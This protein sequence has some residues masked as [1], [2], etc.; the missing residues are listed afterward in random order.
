VAAVAL[1]AGVIGALT[2]LA[3]GSAG[4]DRLRHVGPNPL[5]F[6]AALLGELIIG[7]VLHVALEQLRQR[8][9]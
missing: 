1:S 7:A 4:V 6:T 3:T 8:R 9:G 2:V 5:A